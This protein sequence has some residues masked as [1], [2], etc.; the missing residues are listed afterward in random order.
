MNKDSCF[1]PANCKIINYHGPSTAWNQ[2]WIVLPRCKYSSRATT[3][4]SF[5]L[6]SLHYLIWMSVDNC[7]F[8]MIWKLEFFF[9]KLQEQTGCQQSWCVLQSQGVVPRTQSW[10]DLCML[11]CNLFLACYAWRQLHTWWRHWHQIREGGETVITRCKCLFQLGATWLPSQTFVLVVLWYGTNAIVHFFTTSHGFTHVP[12]KH[13]N[14][15]FFA[16]PWVNKGFTYFF[17]VVFLPLSL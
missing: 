6:H 4:K 11:M 17:L 5:L 2:S 13:W 16:F 1:R 14:G 3:V 7:I 15:S 10:L 9:K 8:C 12:L